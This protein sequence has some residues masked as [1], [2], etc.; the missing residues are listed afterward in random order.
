MCSYATVAARHRNFFYYSYFKCI[1]CVQYSYR[2]TP[3]RQL[4][5]SLQRERAYQRHVTECLVP[6]TSSVEPSFTQHY[7]QCRVL[8]SLSTLKASWVRLSAL[9]VGSG[10]SALMPAVIACVH[11]CLSEITRTCEIF[12]H[13]CD[14]S[15]CV[16][17]DALVCLSSFFDAIIRKRM[18]AC[19][20]RVSESMCTWSYTC[21]LVA[22]RWQ[23]NV[24]FGYDGFNHITRPVGMFWKMNYEYCFEKHARII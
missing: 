24:C 22:W 16:A 9:T 8:V 21:V 3:K 23:V 19:V 18:F 1:L 2:H 13:N 12:N 14:H 6:S 11:T 20:Q 7:V 4:E 15:V 17:D 5:L 10:T